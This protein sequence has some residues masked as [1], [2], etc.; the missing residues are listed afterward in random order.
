MLAFKEAIL[1]FMVIIY[2]LF[3]FFLSNDAVSI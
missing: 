3:S 2:F 1:H